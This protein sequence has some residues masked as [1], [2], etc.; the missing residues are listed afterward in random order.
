MDKDKEIQRLREKVAVL[1]AIIATRKLI[2]QNMHTFGVDVSGVGKGAERLVCDHCSTDKPENIFESC[3]C[4]RGSFWENATDSQAKNNRIIVIGS[5]ELGK[6][7]TELK[8][9][10]KNSHP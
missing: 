10:I 6:T 2:D 5:S 7:T 4:E 9:L 8:E 3:N 1:E